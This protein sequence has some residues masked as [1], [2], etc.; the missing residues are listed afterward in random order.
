MARDIRRYLAG[1]P[2]EARRRLAVDLGATAALDPITEDPWEA[3]IARDPR[4]FRL[5]FECSGHPDALQTIFDACGPLGTV[6]IL[7]IPMSP[8]LLLRMTVREQRAFSIAGPTRASMAAAIAHLEVH[9]ELARMID[10]VVGLDDAASTMDR[11]IAGEVGPKIL[12]D[13]WA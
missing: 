7:G 9:P 3:G 10:G 4:G 6:G 5:A 12:I 11:L 2:I 13:P 1:D 8:V